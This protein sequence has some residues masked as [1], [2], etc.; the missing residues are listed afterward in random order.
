M[1]PTNLLCHRYLC[2]KAARIM[3]KLYDS[4]SMFF[5]QCRV[6]V[7]PPPPPPPVFFE[8]RCSLD[9]ENDPSV[10]WLEKLEGSFVWE[11]GSLYFVAVGVPLW[12]IYR[13]VG[14]A[15]GGFGVLVVIAMVRP[16]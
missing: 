3:T 9:D 4:H 6:L 8:I 13:P 16:C 5:V 15:I 2:E 10:K 14:M 11:A 12:F 7:P 1:I